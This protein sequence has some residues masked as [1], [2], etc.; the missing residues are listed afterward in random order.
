MLPKKV[1][2]WVFSSWGIL[3]FFVLATAAFTWPLLGNLANS[4]PDWGDGADSTWRLGSIAH[5][6]H[7]DPLH[8]YKT[9]AF[10]PLTNG[11]ALDELLTGQGLLAAPVI[12]LTANPILAFNLLV[13]LSFTLS[14]FSMWLLVRHLTGSS[15]GGLI[16]GL[17]YAFS[18]WHYG[19]YAHLGLGAQQWMIFALFFLIR[20]LEGNTG[21]GAVSKAAIFERN[22]LLRL[23]L[24]II[25][26][27][28]Q[29]ITAGYLAYFEAILVGFYLVYYFLFETGVFAWAWSKIRSLRDASQ[30]PNWVRILQQLAL[31]AL[32]GVIILVLIIPFVI[33][34]MQAQKEFSFKR[35]IAEANYWSAA[36]NNLLRTVDRSWLYKPVERGLFN[37]KTSPERMLYPGLIALVLALI[38][39]WPNLTKKSDYTKRPFVKYRQ[40]WLFALLSLFG[41]VLSFGPELH[42]E[43][44][45]LKPTGISLPYKWFYDYVFGFDALRVPLRFG[46]LFMLGLAI[47]AGYGTARLIGTGIRDSLLMSESQVNVS[48]PA[49]KTRSNRYFRYKWPALILPVLI[50]LVT[51]DFFAPGV[52]IQQTETGNNAQPLYAWLASAQAKE[53]LPPNALLLELPIAEGPSPVNSNPIYLVHSLSHQR[54][55]L[56]G[57]ANIVPPDYKRLFFE[58]QKFPNPA[59]L[60]IIEGI[61]VRYLIVHNSALSSDFN[62]NELEK[63]ASPGGR[64][65]TVKSFVDEKGNRHIIYRVKSASK[66]FEKLKSVIPSGAEVL[67]AEHPAKKGLYTSLLPQLLGG[68]RHY[69]SNY[70]SIYSANDGVSPLQS[71]KVYDYAIFYRGDTAG[72]AK[73]GYLQSDLLYIDP[74]NAFEVYHKSS[75]EKSFSTSLVYNFYNME[76]E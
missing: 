58:M 69:F 14:G 46:Q 5:Q 38:G 29:A 24:F 56:N 44:Y 61:G 35:D 11:L 18:P 32:A 23:G 67:L 1:N 22:N 73:N 47:C 51:A 57:S 75:S 2:N 43:T 55:M 76:T 3:A 25:F 4:L 59:S 72:V 15:G 41:L 6:L 16:S 12:W 39:L 52:P 45:A 34:F 10:Y 26:F 42:L 74:E 21:K 33:P 62:R 36:P 53:E 17:I 27:A 71:G 68:E 64:L 48:L 13:Y 70:K 40:R 37:L 65:K 30:Q 50:V 31:L 63:Q 9:S 60:D 28:F 54:P 7:T 8:L 19:Q 20:F 66:R 49:G